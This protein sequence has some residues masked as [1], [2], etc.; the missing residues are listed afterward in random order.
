MLLAGTSVA[1]AGSGS[2]GV[3]SADVSSA[4]AYVC[5][6][7]VMYSDVI[8]LSSQFCQV[9]DSIYHICFAHHCSHYCKP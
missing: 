3:G 6:C 7:E 2:D 8:A 1:A 9:L 4:S 5:S